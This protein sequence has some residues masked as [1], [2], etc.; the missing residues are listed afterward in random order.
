MPVNRCVD[1]DVVLFST[2]SLLIY[3]AWELLQDN[4]P[5]LQISHLNLKNPTILLKVFLCTL[6]FSQKGL[7]WL[8]SWSFSRIVTAV[9]SVLPHCL[10]PFIH[11]HYFPLF[12]TH[13]QFVHDKTFLL[14]PTFRTFSYSEQLWFFAKYFRCGKV[15][16]V[17]MAYKIISLMM[18]AISLFSVSRLSCCIDRAISVIFHV[19]VASE[20]LLLMS[21]Y[22][23]P[24]RLGNV[25]AWRRMYPEMFLPITLLLTK[26]SKL[27]GRCGDQG[28]S[29]ECALQVTVKFIGLLY[30]PRYLLH[31][32]M[33]T[34]A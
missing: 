32:R 28:V 30:V 26:R 31:Y 20:T 4:L 8:C 29:G 7:F 21:I 34:L 16:R 5:C 1:N 33:V 2:Y 17:V 15:Y 27:R 25:Q 11:F 22:V 9:L 24:V 18:K 10:S 23:E 19:S 14:I 13:D 12:S 6:P 3:I